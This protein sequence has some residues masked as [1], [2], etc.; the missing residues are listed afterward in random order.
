[1]RSMRAG[2]SPRADRSTT[3]VRGWHGRGG[4]ATWLAGIKQAVAGER[5]DCLLDPG[6]EFGLAEGLL[7]TQ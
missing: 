3:A 5:S 7:P 6:A 2:D 1:M 4:V